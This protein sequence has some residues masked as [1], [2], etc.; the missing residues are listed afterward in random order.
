IACKIMALDVI[1][2]KLRERYRFKEWKHASSILSVD[3]PEQWDDILNCLQRFCLRRSAIVVGGGGRS[4]VSQELDGYLFE[5]GWRER[6][7]DIAIR[8][9]G[10][11]IQTP[12]HKIDNYKDGV[13]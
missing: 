3:F 9:D 10:H 5:R 8:V 7:F 4:Q 6:Q 13:A 2:E 12:T 11:E 1:P